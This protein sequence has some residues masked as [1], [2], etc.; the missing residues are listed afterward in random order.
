MKRG[1]FIF[2]LLMIFSNVSTA[3]MRLPTQLN[4]SNRKIVAQILG[5]GS[6]MKLLSNPYPLGGYSGVELGFSSEYIP[7]ENLAS[8]GSKSPD[9]GD[10][11]YFTLSV[12]KGLFYNVDFFLQFTPMPQQEGLSSFGAQVRWGIFET[13]FFPFSLSLVMT[14][15]GSSFSNVVNSTT[16]GADLVGTVNM[17]DVAVYFGAGKARTITTFVGGTSG[18]TDD[19]NSYQVDLL[20]THEV[21]GVS[22]KMSEYFVALEVDRYAEAT[23]SGKVGVRF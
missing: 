4:E 16:Q 21:F 12:G 18:V 5:F 10:Y 9:K 7:F 15:G 6:M 1:L 14:G 3:A 13:N 11:N 2:S 20:E 8:L 19:Q 23:Y 17:K 22:L